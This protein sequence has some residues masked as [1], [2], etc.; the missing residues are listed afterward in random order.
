[1]NDVLARLRAMQSADVPVTGGRTLAYVYD[2]G[3]EEADRV[4]RE[5]V[6]AYAGS[7]GLD[8]TAFPSLMTME[9]EL[10][11]LAARLLDGPDSTVGTVTSG[12][13]ESVLLAVQGARDSRTDIER[14]R[15]VLPV[16]AH[17]AFHK[18]AHYFGVEPV[19]VDVDE[20]F[21]ARPAAMAQAI[22]DRTVLVVASAPS[23]AHGVVDPVAEIAEAAARSGVRCH[24]DAC[25][26]GWVLPYAAR[27]GRPVLP[28]T[29]AV[30]GVTSISVDLHKYAYAPKGTSILLHRTP[31]LRRPQFFASARWPGYTMLNPTMQS[32]KS[33]GPLAGAWAVVNT[34][35]DAGYLALTEKVL[36]GVDRLVAGISGIGAL[37]VVV[38]PEST[39]V[40]LATDGTCD[41]FTITDAMTRAGWY[42]Q[43][44]LSFES[45]EPTIHLS[46]SAATADHVE[47][48]L[49][50]L[51]KA[52]DAAVA[53]GPIAIDPGVVE[54]VQSLDAARLSDEDFDGLLAAVGMAGGD[55]VGLP[56]SMAE[57]NSLLDLAAPA[58]R[59]ALLAAFLDR[60]LRPAR[61]TP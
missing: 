24:V 15:M 29:F 26:G 5:A 45:R 7:N 1:M 25:I 49:A 37:R 40:A 8:P 20:Q 38:P 17:A 21:R 56:E 46:L 6:A 12:G 47:E 33:G 60:L 32:T 28:W 10:V 61:N 3:L 27:L 14:P 48:F 13:T 39:L 23:Y 41:V 11:G 31:A 35:G 36:D 19:T 4:G 22:D 54:F 30:E 57:I 42:V 58:L 52:V 53:S 2:S 18:A 16:T 9:N 43:P 44:Q 34:I 55:G 50:A 51:A 59:E